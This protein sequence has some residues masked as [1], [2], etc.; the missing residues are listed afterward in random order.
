[1]ETVTEVTEAEAVEE[2]TADS[3]VEAV[4][5]MTCDMLHTHT[6]VVGV[7]ED[8]PTFKIYI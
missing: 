7:E 8:K 4:E 6:R 5:V 3:E 2:L 1:M